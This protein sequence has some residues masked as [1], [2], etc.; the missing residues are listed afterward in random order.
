[1]ALLRTRHLFIL[2][3]LYGC[4]KDRG[5]V[6]S[7]S[8]YPT[9]IGKIM[10]G[11]CAL[12]G[13]HNALSKDAAGGISLAGWDELFSGGNGGAVLIPYRPDLSTLCYYTN[14][15]EG[16]DPSLEPRM[17]LNAK[18][19]TDEQYQTIK[20]WIAN[21]APDVNG[22]IAFSGPASNNKIYI[23]NQLCDLVMILDGA[24]KLVMRAVDAGGSPKI[25]F[26]VCVNVAPDKKYWYLSFLA[27]GIFQKFDALYDRC[28]STLDLGEG[29]WRSFTISDDSKTAWCFDNAEA[30]RIAK[31]DLDQM[32]VLQIFSE[33]G[34]VYS[35][36]PVFVSP[37][38]M[39]AGSEFGNYFSVFDVTGGAKLIKQVILDG[40]TE[41][42]HETSEDPV[43]LRSDRAGTRCFVA[44]RKSRE[45]KVV[46]TLKDSVFTTIHLGVSPFMLDFDADRNL[47]FISCTDDSVSFAGHLGSVKVVDLNSMSVIRTIN[48]GYQP[49]GIVVNAEHGYAAVVNSNI[50]PKG[51]GPHHTGGCG[52]RNG[53]VTFIDL[54]TLTLIPG[55]KYELA[56]YPYAAAL[57]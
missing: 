30:G 26:P 14:A 5:I 18:A 19:L 42:N 40:A 53:Y 9:E 57:R 56:V 6:D 51:P 24:S 34:S 47:L 54:N 20:N 45:I 8:G 22:K 25:E 28:V 36:S 44:C 2:F 49:N 37:D 3:I 13:C 15:F 43:C 12:K 39:Y 46:D 27:S 7:N 1:M 31:V 55:K 11:S 4:T 35:E 21:G 16:K 23:T 38:K 29:T 41:I 32:R 48:I 33:P 17:P 10:V 52:G 50:S